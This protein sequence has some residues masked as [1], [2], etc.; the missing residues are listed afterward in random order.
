MQP[1][2]CQSGFF[3]PGNASGYLESPLFKQSILYMSSLARYV[4][5]HRNHSRRLVVARDIIVFMRSQ[6]DHPGGGMFSWVGADATCLSNANA[7]LD[8]NETECNPLS[9][10]TDDHDDEN[11]TGEK[12]G[13][14]LTTSGTIASCAGY[15][16]LVPQMKVTSAARTASA[17]SALLSMMITIILRY[18]SAFLLA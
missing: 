13:T 8:R 14:G 2:P 1:Q 9:A 18:G 16:P 7:D 11:V 15:C 5:R 4:N 10:H 12:K 6:S 3:M 17:Y